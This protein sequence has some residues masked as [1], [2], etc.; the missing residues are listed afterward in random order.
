MASDKAVVVF[1]NTT[2]I[3]GP[4]KSGTDW[5]PAKTGD[6]ITIYMNGLGAVTPAIND[7]W[8]SCDQ[9]ICAPDFSNLTLRNTTVRPVVKIGGVTVP[10]NL[11]LFSGLA[12]AVCGPVSDQPYDSGR[13]HAQ[14]I[15]CRW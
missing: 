1:A 12:P 13:N 9:S 14:R 7:G 15:R 3:V 5:R 8:N 11:I 2:T 6:T 4:I 10:D